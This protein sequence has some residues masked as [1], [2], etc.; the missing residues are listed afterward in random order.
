MLFRKVRST[1]H[2]AP[3]SGGQLP[4][5]RQALPP[6]GKGAVPAGSR[7]DKAGLRLRLGSHPGFSPTGIGRRK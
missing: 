4:R 3:S 7:Q 6:E 1:R 5:S 2:P